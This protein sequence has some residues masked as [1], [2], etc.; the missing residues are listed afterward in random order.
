MQP[1]RSLVHLS[2]L[3]FGAGR[4]LEQRCTELVRE[5]VRARIDHVVVTGDVT[6]RGEA[7][8]LERFL[9]VFE[10]LS[11]SGR[12]TVVPGN[13]DRLGDDVAELMMAGRRVVTQRRPGL[14]LVLVDSTRA[15]PGWAFVAH[16]ELTA[17]DLD[18]IDRAVD[19]AEPDALV[20]VLLHHHP[21][22]IPH[23]SHWEALGCALGLPYGDALTAG[24]AL[25]ARL[26]GRCDLVLHGHRHRPHA[27]TM[28]GE[29]TLGIYN[30]GSSPALQRARI[31]N[32]ASGRLIEA[33][34]WI[35]GNS[36][37]DGR[38]VLPRPDDAAAPVL[39]DPRACPA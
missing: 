22:P 25:L 24:P 33:P 4:R 3:H 5:L 19:E 9:E 27:L 35:G 12:L 11:R 38:D 8:E 6:E 37:D 17:S 18:A 10:P 39:T 23:E 26:H 36:I 31:F 20:V 13:H 14:H 7:A 34:R 28:D 30:A 16:G 2:D 15:N 29:R 21:V 32:H 1:H